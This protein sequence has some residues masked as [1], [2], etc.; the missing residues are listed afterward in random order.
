MILTLHC[1][2]SKYNVQSHDNILL[3]VI[4]ISKPV[5]NTETY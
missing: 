5:K 2:V 1:L 4:M 3:L